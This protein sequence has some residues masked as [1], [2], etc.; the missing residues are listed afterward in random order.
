MAVVGVIAEY[1]PFH[2][3]HAWQPAQL[4][5]RL[6]ADTAVIACMSGN[7]VQRGDFA[8][9][10]KHRRAETALLGGADLVLELPTPWSA[11][12]AER[13]AQ[14]GV[15]VL[16]AAG[17]VTHLAFG[18]ECGDL[19]P[20]QRIA[21]AL[22]SEEYHAGLRRFLDEGMTF[23]VARQGAIWGL[24]SRETAEHLSYPNNSLA[25]EYLRALAAGESGITPIALPRTGAAHDSGVE[26]AYS[27]ASAIR[28]KLFA[29]SGWQEL[30]I[31]RAHV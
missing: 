5:R 6:G 23:A 30:Q 27:S 18:C 21:E 14:G 3:G 24:T 16:E 17:I 12:A 13:F 2:R 10:N 8:V 25:V 1:N 29:G 19:E 11:A 4:R 7:F 28:G 15:A 26:D 20:L 31:G 9:L 22:E